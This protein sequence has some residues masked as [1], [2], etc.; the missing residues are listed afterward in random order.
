M[1]SLY[2]REYSKKSPMP[3]LEFRP[4][5]DSTGLKSPTVD[6]GSSYLRDYRDRF[7]GRP[8]R[9]IPDDNLGFK[10]P[11]ASLSNYRK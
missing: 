5:G 7:P 11:Q 8:D 9:P 4:V 6:L 3:R 10:G 1:D 2:R